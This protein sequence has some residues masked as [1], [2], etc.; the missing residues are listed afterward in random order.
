VTEE[1]RKEIITAAKSI[2]VKV[3][4]AV[5][6]TEEGNLDHQRLQSL[7]RQIKALRSQGFQ[8]V[9]VTSGAI[10]AGM[11]RLGLA[12]RPQ[13]LPALQAA[14]AVGQGLLMASYDEYFSALGLGVA[15]ILLTRGDFHERTRYL[16]ARNTISALLDMGVVPIINENDTTATDE[17][18][19]GDNDLLSA[20]VALSIKADLLIMLSDVDGLYER[21]ADGR[22]SLLSTVEE[23]TD[24]VKSLAFKGPS[25][26]GTGGM[27]SKL[28]AASLATSAGEAVLVAN[29]R[30]ENILPEIISGSEVGTLFKPAKV[31]MA[32]RKRWIGFGARCRG[33]IT[34]DAG[35]REAL[36]ERGKSLLASGILAV[37]GRF[38]PGDV[39]A[40]K[41]EA[42]EEF[43]RGLSNYS[44]E[45]AH[46]IKGRK[47]TEI[48]T[49]L[50]FKP[51]DEVIH[52]DNLVILS[53]T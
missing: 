7:A 21:K 48:A 1:A 18:K 33:E 11:T 41:D 35:A 47:T 15:Q 24:E 53:G 6:T 26:V 2:V 46:K 40:I 44:A 13:T 3:G 50:G 43:A 42:G 17:I 34:V 23:I 32:S 29:G 36:V 20:L 51:Y 16:N 49:L 22:L 27:E 19:F 30:K 5:L 45:D 8:V 39:V 9:V 31:R 4:T 28:E 52:R 38:Q 37:E 25:E 12:K 14:A 10:V